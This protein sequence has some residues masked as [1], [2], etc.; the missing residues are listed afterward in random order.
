MLM[1]NMS[2]VAS[3]NGQFFATEET[4]LRHTKHSY[5]MWLT[6]CSGVDSVMTNP[7]NFDLLLFIKQVGNK[8]IARII[9]KQ[10]ICFDSIEKKERYYPVT[11]YLFM[12]ER[13]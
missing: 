5:R 8:N 9:V 6:L 7:F 4:I 12:P 3:P 10:S 1:S 2:P 13:H 11:I